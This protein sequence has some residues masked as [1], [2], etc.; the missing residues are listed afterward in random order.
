MEYGDEGRTAA[1]TK[2]ERRES[3][4]HWKEKAC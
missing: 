1:A 2:G 4:C 3:H